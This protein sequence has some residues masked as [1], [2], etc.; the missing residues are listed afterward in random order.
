M[1]PDDPG[2]PRDERRPAGRGRAL[3][4]LRGRPCARG[5]AATATATSARRSSSTRRSSCAAIGEATDIVEKEMYIFV[6]ALN[7]EQPD[8]APGGTAPHRARGD[9]ALPALRRAAAGLVHAGPMFRH[10]RPQKGRYRQF[11]QFDVE[12]LGFAGP[13]VDAELMVMCARLWGDLGIDGLRAASQFAS[14]VADERRAHRAAAGR[15]FRSGTR[16][17]STTMR[18]GGCITNP[19]RM[20]DSKNPAMQAIDRRGAAADRLSRR[21]RRARTSRACRRC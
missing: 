12:A 9:R 4:A 5:R 1:T 11:H 16:A 21:R 10:E 3:G 13:D 14:A 20:L 17:S 19:L 8:P 2:D 15:V 18:A 6:D 7:G